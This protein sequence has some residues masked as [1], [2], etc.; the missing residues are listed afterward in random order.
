MNFCQQELKQKSDKPLVSRFWRER[1][2]ERRFCQSDEHCHELSELHQ[3]G[4]CWYPRCPTYI[5]MNCQSFISVVCV[6]T[7]AAL[8]TYSWTVR[9]SSV[10]SML[11]PTLPYI[12]IHELSELHRC[13]PCWYPRSP[14]YIFMNCQSFISVVRVDT[15][16]PLHTYSWAVRASSVWSVFIP[17]LPYIHSH[18]LSEL[19]QCGPCWYPRSPTYTFT[20]CQSFIGVVCVDTQAAL[21]TYSWTVRASSV[22]SVLVPTLP[23]IHIHELSE[24]HQSGQCWYPRSPTYIFMSCQ[25]F[26]SV[27]RVDTHAPLHTY[28]W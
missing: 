8:H 28:S 27:V 2:M 25:S 10:W 18:E 4:P 15:H 3:S 13:G 14:T 16:A 21:H 11:I 9:A 6:D 19:H 20:N 24:L 7:H 1:Q 26:I 22:W 5:F 17:T 12:H 23:Y